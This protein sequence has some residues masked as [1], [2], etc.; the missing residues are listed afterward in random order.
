MARLFPHAESV[1]FWVYGP[2]EVESLKAM[3]RKRVPAEPCVLGDE[4][5]PDS[6]CRSAVSPPEE[7]AFYYPGQDINH[8]S[9]RVGVG[10]SY[11]LS[12]RPVYN[13]RACDFAAEPVLALRTVALGSIPA[14]D[15]EWRRL[16]AYASSDFPPPGQLIEDFL[17]ADN[18]SVTLQVADFQSVQAKD[19]LAILIRHEV[20]GVV[21]D[22]TGQPLAG[23]TLESRLVSYGDPALQASVT[24]QP[25]FVTSAVTT[26]PDG[27][28]TL[29][30]SF[31]VANGEEPTEIEVRAG[32]SG[33][34]A[35]IKRAKVSLN[36][37]CNPELNVADFALKKGGY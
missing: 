13:N 19:D 7:V 3:R 26:G 25:D 28:Y 31:F 16:E 27:S 30:E 1:A 14:T 15:Q 37:E 9:Y 24:D 36:S 21:R 4:A 5:E 17:I 32:K 34:G 22:D 18:A 12:L 33:Y 11:C 23:V 20:K 10:Q 2:E 8:I 29:L 6:A 35:T